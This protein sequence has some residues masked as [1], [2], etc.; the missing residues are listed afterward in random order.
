MDWQCGWGEMRLGWEG[1]ARTE[2]P[3]HS[4][5][6]WR[7]RTRTYLS[8]VDTDLGPASPSL[9]PAENHFP[10][11][12]SLCPSA[13]WAPQPPGQPRE[14]GGGD[15]G[16][17]GS[18]AGVVPGGALSGVPASAWAG[19]WAPSCLEM[20][21]SQRPSGLGSPVPIVARAAASPAVVD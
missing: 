9:E 15:P 2:G 1:P 16:A 17:I 18:Q 20:R 6:A 13:K 19:V 5:A 12:V 11:W 21:R 10:F 7:R 14:L 8:H 3:K 4:L